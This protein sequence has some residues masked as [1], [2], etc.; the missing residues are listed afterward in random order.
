MKIIGRIFKIILSFLPAACIAYMIFSFSGQT[1]IESSSLSQKVTKGIVLMAEKI[2]N[3][4]WSEEEI[5]SKIEKYEYY[6]RKAA[7][8]TEYAIL[9]FAVM[10]PLRACGIR[11]FGLFFLTILICGGFAATD[12]MH[13]M[14]VSGRAA[15]VKDVIIDC[16]GAC[17]GCGFTGI[18]IR[19]F[20]K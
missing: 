7:H 20:R 9:A 8:M 3:S 5:E 13:Q 6:V 2:T 18:I 4:D 1:G 19:I 16:A 10:L 12:E 14:Y 11:G 15:A 17:I